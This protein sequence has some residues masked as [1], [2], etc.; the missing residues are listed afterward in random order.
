M[1]RTDNGPQFI[2]HASKA[3]CERF[4]IEHERIPLR[5]PNRNAHIETFHRLLEEEW[6]GEMARKNGV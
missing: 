4:E 3:A 6:L 5:T 2:S 1:I